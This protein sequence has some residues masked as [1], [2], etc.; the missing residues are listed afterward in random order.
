MEQKNRF[1]LEESVEEKYEVHPYAIFFKNFTMVHQPMVRT[2]SAN[3]A[4]SHTPH[5]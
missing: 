5:Y 4:R 2:P 1:G 3:F